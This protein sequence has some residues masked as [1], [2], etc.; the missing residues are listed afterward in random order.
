M[1]PS[2][3][4]GAA[5]F[6][7]GDILIVVLYLAGMVAVGLWMSRGQKSTRDYFL[8]SRNIPWWAV[9]MAIIATE[10]SALT[11]I[12]V[13]AMAF[14][15]M[16]RN[17]AGDLIVK[18]GTGSIDFLQIIIGY[19]IARVIIAIM[20]VP[21]YFKGEVYSPYQILLKSFGKTPRYLASGF[22]LLQ[23]AMGAG[24][25]IYVTAIPVM[26]VF[27]VFFPGWGI[28]YSILLFTLISI[29]YTS[30]GGI[31]AV[32]W[33]DVIQ[34]CIFV[35]GGL[36]ALFYVPSLLEGGWGEMIDVGRE[37]GRLTW[38]RSGVVSMQEFQSGGGEG[39]GAFI[40]AN[41]RK[42]FGGRFNIWMGLI[43]ATIGVMCSHGVDQLN[44]Q[45]VL[46]CK[47]A[48][49]GGKALLLSAVLIF[50]LFLMFLMVGV[51][52]F[53]FYKTN[54]FNFVIPPW[55][56]LDP[57]KVPKADYVFPIFIISQVPT[58]LKGLLIAGILAAAMSSISGALSA[59][60]S[61]AVMDIY[62]VLDKNRKS[63]DFYFK[64]SRWGVVLVSIVLVVIAYLSKEAPLVFN[65]AFTLVGLTS[66]ALLGAILFAM[67]YK[68]SHPAP[69]ITGMIV[70]FLVMTAII[71]SVQKGYF[72]M[73][74][75]WFTP[76]GTAVTLIICYG[77]APFFPKP[78]KDYVDVYPVNKKKLE[79]EE[80][81]ENPED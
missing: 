69:V 41:I 43:G 6:S 60:G 53:A 23:G 19:V 16:G 40:I 7:I 65:L 37:T 71:V 32:V 17:E 72:N 78:E 46:T 67:W 68:R 79:S 4:A 1:D 57:N 30:I 59:L 31:K 70:S 11:F 34:F 35:L 22:F 48:R 26:I 24:V 28:F 56:P 61:V 50:P 20:M 3:G 12:G 75:P 13:P 55:N 21:H 5:S 51:A 27:R 62:R 49:E 45:R 39:F 77:M 42:I 58:L 38:I 73:N 15:T 66:G 33:T 54:G 18:A 47:N 81:E 63:E 8:G 74:W 80:K 76:I 36:Y 44:V 29:F 9:G 52:L 25:R 10:T 64:L 14:G 2:V